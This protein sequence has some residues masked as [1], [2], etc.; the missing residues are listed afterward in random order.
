MMTNRLVMLLL[1]A[2]GAPASGA[3][4]YEFSGVVNML[5]TGQV[6]HYT[7]PSFI[8]ADT[9]VPASAMDACANQGG[10]VLPCYGVDF[11][12]SGPD[13]PQHYP[14]LTFDTLNPDSS[15]G[16]IFYYFPLGT[17]FAAAGTLENVP[18]IG[19]RGTLT[20]SEAIPVTIP[21]PA[22]V[23]VGCIAAALI[24]YWGI[25]QRHWPK[26][27]PTSWMKLQ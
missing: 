20:I 25:G 27:E 6:F 13:T 22:T 9:F 7:A 14:E 4:I 11:L 18:T 10:F 16:K 19:N 12:V 21:E 5:G 1:L 23:F 3:V 24:G 15:I 2:C 26:P 17:S 8:T